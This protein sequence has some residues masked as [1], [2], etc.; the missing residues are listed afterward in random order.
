MKHN[1]K[2]NIFYLQNEFKRQM[3]ICIFFI[4]NLNIIFQI[5]KIFQS[6]RLADIINTNNN[7][8]VSF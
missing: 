2:S 7:N 8:N 1:N 3:Y 5:S 6:S 4:K